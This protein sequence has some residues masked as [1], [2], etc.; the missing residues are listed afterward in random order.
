MINKKRERLYII[1]TFLFLSAL[2]VIY[3]D[4]HLD[5]MGLR[6]GM[7][8]EEVKT[9]I[10]RD[11]IK[12]KGADCI[13]FTGRIELW[14]EEGEVI[15]YFFD[16]YSHLHQVVIIF[17]KHYLDDFDAETMLEKYKN[18]RKHLIAKYGKPEIDELKDYNGKDY[19]NHPSNY[20]KALITGSLTVSEDWY[21]DNASLFHTISIGMKNLKHY[22]MISFKK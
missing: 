18:V 20:E 9:M 10:G 4:D 16:D 22:I 19:N 13:E 14:G 8:L 6:R 17:Y 21:F 15:L 2:T 1:I 12:L 7:S 3:A 11:Y 5:F